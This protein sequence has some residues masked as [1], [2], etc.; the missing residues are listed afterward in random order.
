MKCFLKRKV[1]VAAAADEIEELKRL[2]LTEFP[3]VTVAVKKPA[4]SGLMLEINIPDLHVGKPA[5]GKETGGKNY[6]TKIAVSTFFSALSTLLD[7]VSHFKFEQ[8]LMIVGNDLLNADDIEGR[9]TAGTYVNTDGR[10]HKT[11]TT[12]RKSSIDR[13]IE[14]S[15]DFQRLHEGSRGPPRQAQPKDLR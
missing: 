6:D 13:C 9:T 2:A 5:W 10:Y 11:F 15:R 7:R 8:I 12:T 4:Q 1:A 14:S 3:S